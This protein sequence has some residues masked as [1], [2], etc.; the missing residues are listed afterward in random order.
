MDQVA[1]RYGAKSV[2]GRG[3]AATLGR[4]KLW[5]AAL[6]G[7]GGFVLAWWDFADGAEN[8]K[9]ASA[10]TKSWT[11]AG[12]YH[13]RAMATLTLS[14]GELGTAIAIAKPFFD[15]LSHNAKTKFARM[16]A[17]SMGEL[18]KKLGTQAARLLLARLVVGAFWIGLILTIAI[19][20]LEDD[21]LE[22]WCRRCCFRI[23]KTAKPY[24]E[25]EELKELHSAFSE[26]L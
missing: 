1:I 23:R 26:V 3:A 16:L 2:T 12:A 10:S 7:T 4:L 13:T 21:A 17:S 19:Y 6:A 20:L 11:L 9:A 22:K 15:Y 8:F 14:I 5:G 24:E 18:A 25:H